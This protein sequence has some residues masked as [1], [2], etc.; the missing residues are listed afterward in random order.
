MIATA[1][2]VYKEDVS[3][4]AAGS[5]VVGTPC[6]VFSITA[7]IEADGDAVINF[8][9]SAASYSNA[10]RCAKIVLCAEKHTETLVFPNGLPCS[11]GLC[12]TSNLAG[13]DVTVTYE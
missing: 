10:T 2:K 12:A 3:T 4:L 9:N 6:V 1:K 13:V 8:S 7:V 11:S 5:V